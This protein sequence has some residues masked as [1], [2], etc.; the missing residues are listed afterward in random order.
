MKGLLVLL[1]KEYQQSYKEFKLFW[2]PIVF[3]FL[4]ISQPIT[5][6]FLP[7][8]LKKLGGTEGISIIPIQQSGS[9]VL[10]ATLSSQFD[11]L[12]MMVVVVATMGTILS[13]KNNGMLD[14]IL[15]KPV[16]EWNY[17]IS[18]WLAN[19]SIVAIGIILGYYASIYYT[20]IYYSA[21]PLI[22]SFWA[23]ICF[24]LWVGW[25]ISLIL[26]CSTFFKSQ[27]M[28]ALITLG[29]FFLLKLVASFDLAINIIN[30]AMLSQQAINFLVTE[31]W[32]ATVTGSLVF[33]ISTAA[34]LIY[35]S[36]IWIKHRKYTIHA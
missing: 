22:T 3:L 34:I 12:G 24:L 27:G 2:L 15:T 21:V 17:I 1:K 28:V 18:K 6:Y 31:K 9:E 35:S 32:N 8:I 10:S 30:P 11:Q 13:E 29:V 16:S 33:L 36:V 4:G 5:L 20:M 25:I 19:F 7:E 23:L 26:F 14:F